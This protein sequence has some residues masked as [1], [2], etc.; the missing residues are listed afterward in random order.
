MQL[1]GEYRRRGTIHLSV[2][3]NFQAIKTKIV[4][5]WWRPKPVKVNKCF[6]VGSGVTSVERAF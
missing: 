6:V 2:V 4:D 1:G 5:L 3:E